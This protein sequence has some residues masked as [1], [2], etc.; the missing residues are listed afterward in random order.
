MSKPQQAFT[1]SPPSPADLEAVLLKTLPET[2]FGICEAI[3]AA[4]GQ[5]W[6]VGGCVRDLLLGL[7]PK[8]F[9]LEV[10]HLQPEKLQSLLAPLGRC[11]QVGRQFGVI[12]FWRNGLEIDIALPRRERKTAA[13]HRGFEVICD[14]DLEPEIASERRDFTINAMMLDPLSC[15][16][17][18]PHGGRED[19]R[20]GLLRHVSAA[21]SEDPL[22]PLRA[23]Q[24]A[25]RFKLRLHKGTAELCRSMLAEAATLPP[26]RIWLEWQKWAHAA[27]PSFGLQ[28]LHDSSW[29]KLYPQL[30]ALIGCAQDARWHPEGD[31]WTHTLLVVDQAARI[32]AR[33]HL[34]K[35]MREYLVFAALCHD[36]GKPATSISYQDGRIGSPG[37]SEAGI[38]IAEAFLKAIH[39]PKRISRFVRPLI[40]DHI[41]HLHGEPSPR[42]VRRLA[43][44]LVPASIELWEM[45]VEADAS[46]R[47]PAPPSRPALAWLELARKLKQHQ[48]KPAPIVS[49]RLLMQLGMPPGPAMGK[50][51]RQAYQAQLDGA[52][53]SMDEALAWCKSHMDQV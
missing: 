7:Q 15:E 21:F 36:F 2:L 13:G 25:A 11:Q 14:P 18:D 28:A 4:G 16:L 26:S 10:Y 44:R 42:A 32:A 39:A 46:G 38:D 47:H 12:K 1:A 3:K 30:M 40:L 41:T 27:H 24:F 5:A 23:M 9:D 50:M 20:C 43:A 33:N 17:L 29:L 49:G 35:E 48:N 31:V 45:L 53:A 51:I 8:D 37:H 19:L 6:L 52:F 22:R 34:D